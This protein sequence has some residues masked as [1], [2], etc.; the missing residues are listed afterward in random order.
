MKP[1][2]MRFDGKRILLVDWESAFLND[3]Y[4]DLAI[5]ANFFVKDQ[6][7][8][9]AYLSTYF[10]EPAG[11]RSEY[12][13]SRFYLMRQALS[14]FYASLLLLEASRAGLSIDVNMS[15]PDFRDYHQDLI[16]DKIDMLTPEAKAQY[17][18]LHLREALHNMRTQRFEE[19][20]ARVGDAH[21]NS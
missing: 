12:R 19:S 21:A 16:A 15:T 13:R 1:Q 11:E 20:V 9:K 8:E 17:G 4:V 7:D 14:M 18:I 5:A 2:N 3:Q 6:A 10:G